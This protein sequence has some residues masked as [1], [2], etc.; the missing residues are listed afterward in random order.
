VGR[1]RDHDDLHVGSHQ[2]VSVDHLA[3]LALSI[4]GGLWAVAIHVNTFADA[5]GKRAEM[6]APWQMLVLTFAGG[7]AVARWRGWRGA[8]GTLAV[9]ISCV[10]ALFSISDDEAFRN[11]LP[12]VTYAYQVAIFA[13]SALALVPCITHLRALRRCA[14][15]LAA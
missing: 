5:F 13:A 15:R 4:V 3:M 7:L 10:L 2:P 14:R 8:L 9:A 1:F 6:A 12:A 11:G